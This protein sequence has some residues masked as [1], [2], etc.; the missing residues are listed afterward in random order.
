MAQIRF[1]QPGRP[2]QWNA[3]A[4]L[5]FS[6]LA[7]MMAAGLAALYGVQGILMLVQD[8]AVRATPLL[9][10]ASGTVARL[11]MLVPAAYYALAR[12]TG[13]RPRHLPTEAV[14]SWSI[15]AL[16]GGALAA[17]VLTVRANFDAPFLIPILSA[18]VSVLPI[19]LIL[20]VAL[21][22]LDVGSDLRRW[23]TLS[24]GMTAG[25]LLISILEVVLFLAIALAAGIYL[26]ATPGLRE[27]VQQLAARLANASNEQAQL[28]LLLPYLLSPRVVFLVILSVC[29]LTPI[30]EEALKPI[31]VWLGAGMITS[32][33]QGF[34][35]GAL[36]GAGFAL[37][38]NLAAAATGGMDW[39]LVVTLRIGT[40]IMHIANAGLM[41]WALVGAWRERRLLRLAI[42]YAGAILVHGLWN[43]LA[44][45]YGMS[46]LPTALG[47]AAEELSL[48]APYA[49]PAMVL[50]ASIMFAALIVMNRRLQLAPYTQLAVETPQARGPD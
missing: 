26:V 31:A 20:R 9:I 17:G 10:T 43:F 32:P 21:R 44:L 2:I 46:S 29:V 50:L 3:V 14:P 42:V 41:G 18:V 12:I 30:V 25:P 33:A 45:A 49:L 6:G 28:N 15:A 37:F 7:F 4:L 23:G 13:L 27:T 11:L 40:A 19:W 34:A 39:T 5:A 36:C 35:L 1:N 48:S 16:W 24:L 38:E 22:G 47:M 8:Q